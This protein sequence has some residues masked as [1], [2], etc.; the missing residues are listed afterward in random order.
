M[1]L[2]SVSN[3]SFCLLF[4]VCSLRLMLN[5][6][7]F[8]REYFLFFCLV[9][10]PNPHSYFRGGEKLSS[11]LLW[12]TTTMKSNVHDEFL[13]KML[14]RSSENNPLNTRR[15]CGMARVD[16]PN[17]FSYFIRILYFPS[18]N[19]SIYDDLNCK[20]SLLSLYRCCSGFI[21]LFS[22]CQGSVVVLRC[23]DGWMLCSH[24][25][26]KLKREWKIEE[27]KLVSNQIFEAGD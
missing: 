5:L 23:G 11:S 27:K 20:F 24:C 14:V 25:T 3:G 22:S 18:F 16:N 9:F 21:Y 7:I 8:L 6:L 12:L 26:E 17:L 2:R 15:A 13:K 19:Q 10:H 1:S 4:L